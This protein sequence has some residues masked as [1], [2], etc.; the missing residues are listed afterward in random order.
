MTRARLP[1]AP[2]KRL[3]QHF[4]ADPDVL[5][6]ILAA[7]EVGEASQVLEVG[8][9]L[10]VLTSELARAVGPTGLVLAV[11]A[12]RDLVDRLRD[13]FRTVRQVKVVAGDILA[14]PLDA[15]LQPPYK[16]VANIPYSITSPLITKF[17]LGDYKGRAGETAPRPA[18][19]TLLVQ[20]EVA[21]RLSAGPGNRERGILTVLIELFG[22]ASVVGR[23]P[24]SAFNP[25]PRVDSAILHI[26]MGEPAANPW[27]LHSLLKA[28][29]ANK[30][31]QLHNAL[32]G[33]LHLGPAEAKDLLDR[34]G[35]DPSSRAEQL[36]LDAWLA[37]LETVRPTEQ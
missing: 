37:L 4:L 14:T 32:G 11:E 12:D 16:L 35:I 1:V 19:M 33:S 9:G 13:R 25:P 29:F 8:P 10:G 34:A 28:G 2:K 17:L 7:A 20:R 22:T 5:A 18:S 3:G 26:E 31:R 6:E 36:P 21:A 24:P 15:L 30:R 23:V 27:A